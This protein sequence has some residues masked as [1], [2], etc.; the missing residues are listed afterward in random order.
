[1]RIFFCAAFAL[2]SVGASALEIPGSRFSFGNWNGGAYTYDETGYFSH[3]GVSTSYVHGHSLFFFAYHHGAFTLGISTPQ[4]AFQTGQI[5]PVRVVVDRLPPL[6]GEASVV[7]PSF[8]V[9]RIYDD[10]KALQAAK[11]GQVL[12]VYLAGK[13][14]N[15]DLSGTYRAIDAARK[16][17]AHYR[18]YVGTPVAKAR[19]PAPPQANSPIDQTLLYQIA[20]NMIA[21]YGITDS[22][23]LTR[24]EVESITDSEGVF[25]MSPSSRLYGGVYYRPSN[26]IQ[27]L[28]ESDAADMDEITRGCAGDLLTAARDFVTPDGASAREL[29]AAC[30]LQT[31]VQQINVTKVFIEEFILYVSIM[32][33]DPIGST[34]PVEEEDERR[35][36]S[37]NVVAQAISLVR[38][39][40]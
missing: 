11:R 36:L 7:N 25:W 20:T 27:H 8:A 12:K 37:Q 15:F 38:Q 16:C 6:D 24:E 21:G 14:T 28:R 22:R 39:S 23:Y 35:A 1:M 10:A 17:A 26:G 3:C 40:R 5:L 31:E 9:L 34:V 29:Q 13:V 33:I 4:P 32:Y 19:P 30:K 18:G 2:L